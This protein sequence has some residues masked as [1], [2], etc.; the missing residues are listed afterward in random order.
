MRISAQ[1]VLTGVSA[2][3]LLAAIPVRLI[4]TGRRLKMGHLVTLAVH[5]PKTQ[6]RLTD[7]ANANSHSPGTLRPAYV[8]S[9]TDSTTDNAYVNPLRMPLSIIWISRQESV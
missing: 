4:A 3:L 7:C 9:P 5:A 6:W 1:C 8:K 2:Q